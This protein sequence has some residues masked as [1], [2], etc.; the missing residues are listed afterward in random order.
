MN[1]LEK[2]F[3]G[4]KAFIGFLTAGDPSL[5]DTERYIEI[6]AKSG[7]DLIEIGR[8]HGAELFGLALAVADLDR[9]SVV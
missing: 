5:E 7:C 6:M 3:D 8:Q 2:A 1:K 4:H 9:K